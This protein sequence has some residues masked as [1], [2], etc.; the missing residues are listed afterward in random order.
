MAKYAITLAGSERLRCSVR[1]TP[2]IT[3]STRSGGKTLVSKPTDTRS[4][5]RRSE[6]GFTH[7]ARG[8]ATN[9]IIVT[10]TERYWD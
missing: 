4:D 2:A 8:M 5:R 10:L 1:P 3:S 9:Y 7:P 6:T